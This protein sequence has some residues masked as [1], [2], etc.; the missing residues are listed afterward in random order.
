MIKIQKGGHTII[1]SNETYNTMYKRLG[2]EEVN[3]KKEKKVEIPK[4]EK[5]LEDEI[6][7]IPVVETE[8]VEKPTSKS[9]I[10]KNKK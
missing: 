6:T 8:V 1:C 10:G 3:D 5:K 7:D 9:K 2:Y 4:V